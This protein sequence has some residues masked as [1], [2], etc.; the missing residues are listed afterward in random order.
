MAVC[1]TIVKPCNCSNTGQD[2]LY[3]NK[4]RVFNQTNKASKKAGENGEYRCT[5]C[6]AIVKTVN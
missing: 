2:N 5:V 6:G 1:T 3:G 4:N